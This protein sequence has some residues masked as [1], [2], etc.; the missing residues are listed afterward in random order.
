MLA[1]LCSNDNATKVNIGMNITI[2]F[3]TIVIAFDERYTDR[4]T[5]K[6]QSTPRMIAEVI[7]KDILVLVIFINE[8]IIISF[9][10]VFIY[11]MKHRLDGFEENQEKKIC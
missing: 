7:F 3:S 5:K 6:L 9:N 11:L 2:T 10:G 1:T 4:H 8:D